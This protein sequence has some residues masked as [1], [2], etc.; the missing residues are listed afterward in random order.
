MDDYTPEELR[1]H[2]EMMARIARET[3]RAAQ[4]NRKVTAHY[5]GHNPDIGAAY[6]I[7]GDENLYMFT[8]PELRTAAKAEQIV[9]KIIL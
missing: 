5:L 6:G 4:Q 1:E 2:A 8:L 9:L 3:L 7:D